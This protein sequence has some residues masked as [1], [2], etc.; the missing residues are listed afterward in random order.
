[1]TM[2]I[3]MTDLELDPWGERLSRVAPHGV[4]TDELNR[5]LD[6]DGAYRV[7]HHGCI[8]CERP[9]EVH[10]HTGT[11]TVQGVNDRAPE[12]TTWE[13]DGGVW[14]YEVDGDGWELMTGYTGQ[15]GYTGPMMHASEFVG[16]RLARDILATPGL[17]AVV[18]VTDMTSG[19]LA[20]EWAV[21]RKDVTA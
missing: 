6:F 5:V 12:V 21:A 16:G 11:V 8:A 3:W 14:P 7:E 19:E 17:Y 15:Y 2:T 1:M 4:V 18:T 20:D 10:E 13:A 9:D